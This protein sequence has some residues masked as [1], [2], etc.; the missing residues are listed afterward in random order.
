MEGKIQ[1]KKKTL[2]S[3]PFICRRQRGKEKP[4]PW[5]GVNLLPIP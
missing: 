1:E 3:I 5:D 4:W 2:E